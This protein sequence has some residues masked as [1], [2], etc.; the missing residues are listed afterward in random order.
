[1]IALYYLIEIYALIVLARLVLSWIPVRA[2]NPAMPVI[3]LIYTVTEPPLS[4]L[5]SVVPVVRIGSGALDLSATILL[6]LL[7]LVARVVLTLA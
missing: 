6:L 7:F 5:R 3:R 4:V 2:D 1:M